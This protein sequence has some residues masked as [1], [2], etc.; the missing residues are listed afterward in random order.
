MQVATF[1]VE[2]LNLTFRKDELAQ[3]EK[4]LERV[5]ERQIALQTERSAPP[6]VKL[7]DPAKPPPAPVEILPFKKMA[8]A[9]LLG[10]CFP[11]ALAVGWEGLSRRISGSEDLEQQ[12]HLAVLGEIT[13]LPARRLALSGSNEA[14]ISLEVRV[15]QE[16]IDSLRTALTLSNDLREMRI[17]AITS[18]VNH[19]GKTS[20]ASQLALSLARATG[21]TTLLIDGDMRAPDV[22]KVFGV[23]QGP[24]LAE[25][26]CHECPLADA[27][28]PTHS[29]H[30]H[31]LP[32]GEI[33]VS[34][35]R[36][37]GNG[38]WKSLV[39]QIPSSYG[40]VIIDTPPVLAASEALVLARAA[41][42]TLLCVMRD[43]SRA[44]QVRKAAERLLIAG[45]RPVGTV[46]SGV[47]M[48]HRKYG[49]GIY[50]SPSNS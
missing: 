42:A 3:A 4:V 41:D 37:L 6:R 50:P 28:V 34:P 17:L 36:L 38:A 40:Y 19:E 47:P 10:L 16:S 32:A 21:K 1:S 18:A 12:L 45:G 9:G 11:F 31:L 43:V 49:Y 7:L 27:I 48:S 35:H 24:G 2:N 30:V 5:T 23:P 46:L 8:L 22:H 25:V 44:D 29:E 13:R 39:E 20:L 33:K 15:F 14:R 26:L